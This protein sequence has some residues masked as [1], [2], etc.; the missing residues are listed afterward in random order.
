MDS[1]IRPD[2]RSSVA[3]R[4]A[5]QELEPL[6][7]LRDDQGWFKGDGGKCCFGPKAAVAR[8]KAS[9]LRQRRG[10][11][12]FVAAAA[13]VSKAGSRIEARLRRA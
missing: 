7:A 12:S 9:N 11:C 1:L 13:P 2:P 4:L 5:V 6:L 3:D 8:Q 10:T